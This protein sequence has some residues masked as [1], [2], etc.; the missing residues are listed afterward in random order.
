MS[1]T[2]LIKFEATTVVMSVPL[3]KQTAW[4]SSLEQ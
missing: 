3:S 4:V 2:L 1:L